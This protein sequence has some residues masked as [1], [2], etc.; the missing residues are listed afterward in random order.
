MFKYLLAVVFN[1]SLSALSAVKV[2]VVLIML[3][4]R[5]QNSQ[6]LIESKMI[7]EKVVSKEE[8]K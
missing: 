1:I 7:V 5:R 3:D 6:Y 4:W 2:A 8:R